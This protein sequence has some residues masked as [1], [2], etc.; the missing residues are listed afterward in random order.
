M[1]DI[2]T[3]TPAAI[4]TRLAEAEYELMRIYN[5]IEQA[6]EGL[7]RFKKAVEKSG[8]VVAR[9]TYNMIIASAEKILAEAPSELEPHLTIRDAAEAEYQRRGRWSRYFLVCNTGGHVHK[10]RHCASCFI[11]TQF[12]WLPGASGQD[13]AGLIEMFGSKV[14]SVCFPEAPIDQLEAREQAAKKAA[15]KAAG[16]CEGHG[17]MSESPQLQYCRPRGTCPVCGFVVTVTKT[18]KCRKHYR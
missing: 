4:D 2:R 6:H 17:Q 1:A 11:T 12:A 7:A 14:C 9:L 5:R 16:F 8:E 3:E 15:D 18:G 10:S 13:S